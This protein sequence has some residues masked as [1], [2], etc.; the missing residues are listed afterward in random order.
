PANVKITPK[1]TVKLLDFGLAKMTAEEAIGSRHTQSPAVAVTVA[2]TRDGRILGTAA[3]MSPEQALGQPVD[4]RTDIWAFGCV[5]YELVTGRR[6]FAGSTVTE[7]MAA[8]VEREPD[9][10]ALPVGTPPVVREV[11]QRCLQKD[12]ARRLP[13]TGARRAVPHGKKQKLH[14]G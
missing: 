4:T 2:G 14:A 10:Q 12:V 6:P 9:W 1:G 3:Y 13:H 8:I 7:T 5:L 11:L